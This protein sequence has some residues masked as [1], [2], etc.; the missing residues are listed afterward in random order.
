MRRDPLHN[1]VIFESF[2]T[3]SILVVDLNHIEVT[4]IFMGWVVMREDL[5]RD[6]SRIT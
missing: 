6:D 5:P 4:G 3:V 2:N 1:R